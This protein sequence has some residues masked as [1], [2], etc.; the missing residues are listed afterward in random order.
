MKRFHPI[1]DVRIS[2]ITTGPT[3]RML[4][5][6]WR[7]GVVVASIWAL[8]LAAF[9][10]GQE[11]V[12]ETEA[13]A[14]T[15]REPSSWD[16]LR[17]DP[18]LATPR[19]LDSYFPFEVPANLEA[20][21]QKKTVL[22]DRLRTVLGLNP[23]PP[24]TP[25]HVVISEPLILEGYSVAKVRFESMPGFYVTG[26][27]YR[28]LSP[29]PS[30]AGAATEVERRP[31]VLCPHGH[32]S[33]GR[34]MYASDENV[35]RELD[36]GAENHE[37]AARSPLQ[38]RCVHL[39][40]MGCVVFHYDMLGNADSV[41]IPESLAHGYSKKRP[42]L[43]AEGAFGLYSVRAESHF[44]SIMGLQ[45]W[46]TIRSLDFLETLP[47]VDPY[48]I[49]VT[50]ASG[51]GTQTFI[52]GALDPRPAVSF[53]AVMVGTAM[54]GGCVCENCSL[55][56]VESGN[57]EFAAMFAPR[58]QG[59]TAADDWTIEMPTKGFPELQQLYDLY[60]VKDQVELT[61]R[62]EFGHNYNQ[63]GRR[64]MY[65]LIARNFGLEDFPETPFR[66]LRDQEMSWFA[67]AE[68][69]NATTESPPKEPEFQPETGEAFEVKLLQWWQATSQQSW[70]KLQESI[71][72]QGSDAKGELAAWRNRLRGLYLGSDYRLPSELA[73]IL[74]EA[75]RPLSE[76]SRWQRTEWVLVDH[77]TKVKIPAIV[78]EP[79]SE[80]S[81]L[82]GSGPTCLYV[83][84][85]ADDLFDEA[86]Q[87]KPWVLQKLEAGHQVVGIDLFGQGRYVAHGNFKM[88]DRWQMTKRESA[89][90]VMGYNLPLISLRAQDILQVLAAYRGSAA[91]PAAG[92]EMVAEGDGVPTLTVAGL[93]W[94]S[95]L[96]LMSRIELRGGDFRFTAVPSLRDPNFLPGSAIVGDLPGMWTLNRIPHVVID[97]MD[98]AWQ[99]CNQVRAAAG[100]P[101]LDQLP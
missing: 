40:R 64:A 24:R 1:E 14:A 93:A 89:G 65:S 67:A 96:A 97:R 70:S 72:A 85:Q 82:P 49:A 44:H 60:G 21:E 5:S 98:D 61:S 74:V 20:W 73:W 81:V 68:A 99:R 94:D 101:V 83:G 53:P 92:V 84:N 77:Q 27:L 48:R 52:V 16:M 55:L 10:Q 69:A 26:S 7:A 63:F 29:A 11:T 51:G 33:R 46:N 62:L 50:G 56:R 31:A 8:S 3:P 95:N 54:Q 15:E 38:A 59:L 6:G 66:V 80:A 76:T 4:A 88:D 30:E 23:E 91:D 13:A 87:P 17:E 42:H 32:W 86:G 58:P 36:A 100:V 90:Y 2:P 43:E 22:Q 47:D 28:P 78:L 34:F 57:V 39:A 45:T 79:V 25:L 37:S 12:Q 41:Q 18:R 75:A 9:V 19:S 71:I 35:K